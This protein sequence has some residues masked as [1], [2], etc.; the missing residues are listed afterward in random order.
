MEKYSALD[1]AKFAGVE[2]RFKDVLKKRS[3]KEQI[4]ELDELDSKKNVNNKIEQI[5]NDFLN[6]DF[7]DIS[8]I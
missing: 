1:A 6:S 3:P 7:V 4:S 8:K 5:R 2:D